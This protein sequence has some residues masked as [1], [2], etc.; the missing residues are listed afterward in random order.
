MKARISPVQEMVL[1]FMRAYFIENDQLPP[2]LAIADHFGW[3]SR[4]HAVWHV[5][6]LERFGFIETNA[7]G[8]KYRFKR[9][10]EEA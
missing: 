6:R 9:E 1:S 10:T 2:V 7:T 4:A 5:R 3:P 8:N